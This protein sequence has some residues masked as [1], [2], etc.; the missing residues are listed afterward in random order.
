MS[1]LIIKLK[2]HTPIIHF[3]HYQE[4]ATL[5]ASELKPK[6]DKFLIEKL[7]D[8][9]TDYKK[10]LIGNEK[11]LALNYK[12]KILSTNNKIENIDERFPFFFGNMGIKNS[13]ITRIKK[14]IFTSEPIILRFFSF[15][16]ELIDKIN[17]FL[18]EFFALENFGSRQ[19]KGFGSFYINTENKNYQ[20][21][22][23]SLFDYKF[24]ISTNG[25]NNKFFELFYQLDLFYRALRPGINLKDHLGNT[26][27][28]FK[29]LLFLYFKN[30]GVQWEKKTIKDNF[31]VSQL[32]NQINKH[33][34]SDV[35]TYSSDNKKLVKDLMGLSTKEDWKFYQSSITKTEAKQDINGR[36]VKKNNDEEQIERFK[37]P[38]F[39]K[40][41]QCSNNSNLYKIYIRL[42]EDIPIRG[43]WF[44]IEEIH[45]KNFPLQ[46]PEHFSIKEFFKFIIDKSKFN[47]S[48]H[49]DQ[50]FQSCKEYNY[51]KNIFKKLQ[52]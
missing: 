37:S 7:R 52:N 2:Q 30:H 42:N 49:V 26:K 1:E 39:F 40:V 11:H 29:S 4:G 31:F 17:T 32:R 43:K 18:P 51:L 20:E 33:Y 41:I 45:G 15:D 16:N 13:N 38:I 14:F 21:L 6:L 22:N 12:I 19:N 48:N 25:M 36:W 47:I 27:F 24:T 50:K 3:Q 44:I 9:N 35:R 5:R 10:F 34:N 23:E 46:I 8:L 28:Y